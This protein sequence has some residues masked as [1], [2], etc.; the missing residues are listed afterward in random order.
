MKKYRI[1]EH[2]GEP[3]LVEYEVV[4]VCS[5]SGIVDLRANVEGLSV[6]N[7]GPQELHGGKYRDTP[8]EAIGDGLALY[9]RESTRCMDN[10]R[11]YVEEFA[12][13]DRAWYTLRAMEKSLH[14]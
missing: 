14:G 10:V 9:G 13:I 2:N 3:V 1:V 8:R 11:F 12:K 7:V 6:Y 5:D 4:G